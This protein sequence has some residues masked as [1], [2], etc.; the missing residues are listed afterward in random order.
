MDVPRAEGRSTC[1][2]RVRVRVRRDRGRFI[3]AIKFTQ[4]KDDYNSREFYH[5]NFAF[6]L[7][8]VLCRQVHSQTTRPERESKANLKLVFRIGQMV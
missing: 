6:S 4:R 5:Q 3:I 1:T 8:C 2:I 7:C